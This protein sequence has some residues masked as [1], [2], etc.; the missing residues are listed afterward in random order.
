[1]DY[2]VIIVKEEFPHNAARELQED[3]K[4]AIDDG[5]KPLGG[6]SVSI[7]SN[8]SNTYKETVMAQ[9]MIKG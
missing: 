6:V 3:V 4:L 9:A 7:S 1:M 8:V 2:K 5:W